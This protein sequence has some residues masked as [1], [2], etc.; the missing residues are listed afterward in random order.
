MGQRLLFDAL[1]P[2]TAIFLT[3]DI[4]DGSEWRARDRLA[5][6]SIARDIAREISRRVASKS[7]TRG[8]SERLRWAEI[9]HMARVRLLSRSHDAACRTHIFRVRKQC[10][11]ALM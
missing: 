11:K 8:K 1:N 4:V 10:Q 3:T 2:N 6:L 5:V 9:K 7:K